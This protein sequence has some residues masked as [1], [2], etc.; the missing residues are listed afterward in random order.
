MILLLELYECY[1]TLNGKAE[2][3]DEFIF[4]GDVILGDFN[5]VDKYLVDPK[6]IFTNVS[7]YK[8]MQDTFSYLSGRQLRDS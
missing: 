6:Q 5:D 4:W 2:P 1:K 3:L 8:A 7:D